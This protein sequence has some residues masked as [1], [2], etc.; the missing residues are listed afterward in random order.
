MDT[1]KDE[2]ALYELVFFFELI[3]FFVQ[4]SRTLQKELAIRSY[5]DRME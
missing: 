1:K 2:F 4:L 3:F 5:E